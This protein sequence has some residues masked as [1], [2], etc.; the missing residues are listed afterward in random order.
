MSS[1]GVVA[2]PRGVMGFSCMRFVIV[3]FPDHTRLLFLW[4]LSLPNELCFN[5]LISKF[6]FL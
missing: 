4:A 2:L 1:D 6:V 3:V 5:L